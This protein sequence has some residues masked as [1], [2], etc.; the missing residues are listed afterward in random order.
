MQVSIVNYSET[1]KHIDFRI[2]AECYKPYH[3]RMD[4]ILNRRPCFTIKDL[5][6]SVINFGAYSLCNYIKFLDKGIPFLVT[7]DIYNN[8]ID[9]ARLHY[10]TKD[11]HKLLYK[12]HCKREQVLLTMAGAYLGQAA[13]FDEDFQCSS[14]QAIAKITLK[15]DSV[16]PYFLSTFLN[17]KYGQSQIERFQTGTGQPNLNLG[18]IQ[19]IKVPK[20]NSAFQD[21]I[22]LCVLS[23]IDFYRRSNKLY[24][25]AEHLLLSELG[26][27]DWQPKHQV[28]FVKKFSDTQETER[29]DAEYF[30]PK[31]DGIV[32]A[33]KNYKGGWGTLGDLMN[34]KDRNFNPKDDV[35]YR[36]I[37]L[38]NIGSN[39]EVTGSTEELGKELPIRARRM[40]S[41][42]DVIVSSIEGSLSGIA[43]IT[44]EFNN[45]FCSTGFY[46]INSE[47]Y[48]SE[49]LLCLAKSVV[50]QMQLKKGCNGTILT[51]INKDEF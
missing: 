51:S 19:T 8:I 24:K 23:G 42:G 37:E 7:E 43:L 38:A 18:L 16:R 50:G 4:Q 44:E 35:V 20:L 9:F 39:G 34:I 45:A 17:C 5:S 13:V 28:A 2:D 29:I 33:V 26:L 14:N 6:I 1:K 3:I 10:I 46:L 31:Y 22:S 40:V 21:N 11:V 36:Y 15:K 47:F 27:A 41:T 48:N 49:T 32:N 25:E 30:Q 12:S